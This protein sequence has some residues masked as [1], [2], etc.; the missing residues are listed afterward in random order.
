MCRKHWNKLREGKKKRERIHMTFCL[1]QSIIRL[2]PP[3]VFSFLPPSLFLLF[4]LFEAKMLRKL[5]TIG[6]WLHF[7]LIKLSVTT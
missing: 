2:S 6:K 7:L 4:I 5:N 3:E 1:Y